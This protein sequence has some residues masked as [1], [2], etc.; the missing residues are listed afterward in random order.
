MGIVEGRVAVVTGGG[1]G[2]GRAIAIALA[3]EGAKVVVNDPGVNV[4][5]TGFD[6]GPADEVVAAI[7]EAGGEAVADYH[8]IASMEGGQAVIQTALDHFRRV[9]ILVNA[10]GILRDRMIFNMTEEEWDAV[11]AVHLKGYFA[12]IRAVTPLMRQQRY[13]R[14]VNCTSM[15]ALRGTSGQANYAAAKG[16]IYGLTKAVARDMGRYGVTCNAVAPAAATRMTTTVPQEALEKRAQAGIVAPRRI[17]P[18]LMQR[19]T[20]EHVAPMVV[21]LCSEEAWNINGQTFF[22]SGGEV[23]LLQEPMPYRTIATDGIWDLSML[24]RLVPEFLMQGIRNP[25]PPAEENI[26]PSQR[27]AKTS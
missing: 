19:R 17:D 3:R 5:G 13:G 16:G 25:A 11:I 7:Q 9:D 8:S 14:I 18:E 22:V 23:S 10:P 27:P 24:R 12:T 26:P 15:A 2:I 21:Y 20:P 1:R 4:D 6:E